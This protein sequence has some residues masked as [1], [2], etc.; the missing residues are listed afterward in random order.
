MNQSGNTIL[1]TGGGSGIGEALAHRFH[2]LGNK[3]VIAGRRTEAL[4]RAAAGRENISIMTLDLE[5]AADV[6]RFAGEVT[7][8]HPALNVLVNN[9]GIMRFERLDGARDLGD[10]EATVITNLL[11]RR[12]A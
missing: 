2:D 7:A 12:S 3:V 4:E 11:G 9:A 10:A 5:S 1:I 6:E 8:R